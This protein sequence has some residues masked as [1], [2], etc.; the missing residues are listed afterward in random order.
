[1]KQ[2]QRPVLLLALGND[3]LGDDGVALMAAREIK[4]RFWASWLDVVESSE[5]GLALM[6][7]MAG[8]HKVV[9]VDSVMTGQHPV[10][11]IIE[12]KREDLQKVVAPSPHYAGIPE[13]FDMASRLGIPFPD[14]IRI[15]AMEVANPYEFQ[16][17]LSPC[18]REALHVWVNKIETVF[19]QWQEKFSC[20]NIL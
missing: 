13:V 9:L 2:P 20:T 18:V 8:Y 15:L 4:R 6:E 1:M 11:T 7:S 16:Q 17:E 3:L 14:E 5:A 19:Y 12:F 10:G